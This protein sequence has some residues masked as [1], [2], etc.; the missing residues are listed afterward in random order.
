MYCNNIATI[1]KSFSG[2]GIN[3][4]KYV[5]HQGKVDH[6]SF[7]DV[8]HADG[9]QKLVLAVYVLHIAADALEQGRHGKGWNE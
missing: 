4:L 7:P 3:F 5:P 8:H 1:T 6:P 2:I 9:R